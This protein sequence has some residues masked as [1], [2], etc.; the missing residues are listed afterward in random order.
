V[1]TWTPVVNVFVST[2]SSVVLP[3]EVRVR[4]EHVVELEPLQASDRPSSEVGRTMRTGPVMRRV[5][6]ETSGASRDSAR[7]LQAN[8]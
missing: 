4:L 6:A 5:S 3:D 1:W 7:C 2:S 8:P